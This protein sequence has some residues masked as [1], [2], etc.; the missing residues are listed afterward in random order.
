MG[1]ECSH[2]KDSIIRWDSLGPKKPGSQW[3][4]C[5]HLLVLEGS[6]SHTLSA[7]IFFLL[8]FFCH[9][10]VIFLSFGYLRLS[11][12]ELHI[13]DGWLIY[14]GDYTTLWHRDHYGL[15]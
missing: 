8:S 11:F 5:H 10:F 14:V 7:L 9:F 6:C 4:T 3:E 12:F 1:F 2:F 15:M 13:H